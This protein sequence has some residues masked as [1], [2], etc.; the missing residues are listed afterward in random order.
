MSGTK[1]FIFDSLEGMRDEGMDY[2]LICLPK[3]KK[4]KGIKTNRD[5]ASVDVYYSFKNKK[6]LGFAVGAV[7]SLINDLEKPQTNGPNQ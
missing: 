4:R 7:Q 2:L 1:D 3:V 6:N 5:R